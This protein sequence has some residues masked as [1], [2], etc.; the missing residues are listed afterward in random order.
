MRG[1]ALSPNIITEAEATPPATWGEAVRYFQREVG[2]PGGLRAAIP[3]HRLPQNTEDGQRQQLLQLS[4]SWA[5]RL[6]PE[7]PDVFSN[8]VIHHRSERPAT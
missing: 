4:Q 6:L 3:E 8:Q 2:K 5:E 1:F 7:R